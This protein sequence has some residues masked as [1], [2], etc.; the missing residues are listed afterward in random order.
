MRTIVRLHADSRTCIARTHAAC[1]APL[2]LTQEEL[3]Y[4][5]A[6]GKPI[7]PLIKEDAFDVMKGGVLRILQRIQWIPF[8]EEQFEPGFAKLATELKKLDRSQRGPRSALASKAKATDKRQLK[9]RACSLVPSSAPE[10]AVSTIAAIN[11]GT[12]S[13]GA[14]AFALILPFLPFQ[15]CIFAITRATR[16]SAPKSATGSVTGI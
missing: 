9:Q 8:Q 4:A 13:G 12:T 2:L 10:K 16:S 11:S 1:S 7:F 5:S 15:T 3:Y 14:S 6:L